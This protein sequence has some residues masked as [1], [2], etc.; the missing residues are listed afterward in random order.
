MQ[1]CFYTIDYQRMSGIMPSL[2][3]NHGLGFFC[4]KV[5]YLAFSLVA[6]LSAYHYHCLR[7]LTTHLF[8]DPTTGLSNQSSIA[9]LI[10]GTGVTTAKIDDHSLVILT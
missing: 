3:T 9:M 8:D 2:E 4:E 7:H 6:P 1:Y 10:L 5:N